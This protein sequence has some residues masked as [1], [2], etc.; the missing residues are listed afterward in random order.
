[1]DASKKLSKNQLDSLSDIARHFFILFN[2][3]E[4]SSKYV[5]L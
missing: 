1:M 3:L 2:H 4:I 5:I